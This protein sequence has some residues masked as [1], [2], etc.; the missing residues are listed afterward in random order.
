MPRLRVARTKL[1]TADRY[2]DGLAFELNVAKRAIRKSPEFKDLHQ[3]LVFQTE[4][5]G[6]HMLDPHYSPKLRFHRET[7]RVKRPSV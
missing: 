1:I 2:P 7:S 4:I 6:R 3:F 5:V